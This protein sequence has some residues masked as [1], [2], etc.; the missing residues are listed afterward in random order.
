MMPCARESQPKYAATPLRATSQQKS[1]RCPKSR[2]PSPERIVELAVREV[3]HNRPVKNAAAFANPKALDLFKDLP[4][5][6]T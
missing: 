1:F 4:E 5:L 2:K 3:I 6:K